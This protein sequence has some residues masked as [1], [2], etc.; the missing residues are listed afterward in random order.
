MDS[1]ARDSDGAGAALAALAESFSRLGGQ[2]CTEP[3][4]LAGRAAAV[5]GLIF[6]WDGVFNE[7]VKSEARGSSFSEPD[8]MGTNLLRYA[9]WRRNGRLPVSA[10]ISGEDNPT[11]ARF[12]AREHFDVVYQGVRDKSS[13]I[14][15]L[16]AT[17]AVA[18]DR[19]ACVFDDV[20][21]LAMARGCAVRV[22]VRRRASPLLERYATARSLCD[23][24]TA[25]E[26][27][28]HAVRE[29]AELLLGLLGEA[30]V[31]FDSRIDF[32]Q[33]FS[34]YLAARQAVETDLRP[35]LSR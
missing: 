29:T 7:G 19:I 24:V 6:D 10:I 35:A 32:D 34:D 4:A 25:A 27:G 5:Q 30:D 2:F 11:A 15:H 23:Y 14:D 8:S 18:R 22:L 17:H 12:A 13:A 31:V 20:N 21:D 1:S 9:L 16:C 33:R 26:G 28:R 3:S